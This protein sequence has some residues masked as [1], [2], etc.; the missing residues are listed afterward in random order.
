[1]KLRE[2]VKEITLQRT[3]RLIIALEPLLLLIAGFAF[4][5]PDP[6]RI[7]ALWL[8]VPSLFAR[9][10]ITR[11]AGTA[12]ILTLCMIG[13]ILLGVLNVVA[14]PYTRGLFILGRPLFGVTFVLVL[15]DRARRRG[16]LDQVLL[17]TALLALLV[18]L[19][20]ILSSQWIEKS[21]QLQFIVDRLP[22]WSG[23]PGAEG[24]FNVNEI[25][26]AMAWLIPASAAIAIHDWRVRRTGWQPTLRRWSAAVGFALM[27]AALFVGQSR[28]AIVGV[29]GAML[30]IVML[31]IPPGRWRIAALIVLALF[32]LFEVALVSKVFDAQAEITIGR[33][34]TSINGR[35]QIWD[36]AL[37]AI[38]DYPLTGVGMNM[39]R[40]AP[41]RER[42]PVPVFADRILPHAHNE[43]LQVGADLGVPGMMVF[44]A[45][46]LTIAV[47]L[48]RIVRGSH[49]DSTAYAAALAAGG[50]LA[51]HAF[52]GLG[53]AITLWDR[54]AFVSWW[55]IGLAAAAY[56]TCQIDTSTLRDV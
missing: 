7:H 2:M 40:S 5:F 26:G 13:L 22:R 23:F 44:A 21:W 25:G 46:H 8:L 31:L 10:I 4:W 28:F 16:G 41:V 37:A 47:M 9:T 34:E 45:L 19:L 33:D 14:A 52:F 18:G 32:A 53:D 51:A 48:L 17:A 38:G 27:W 15:T 42:Y 35:L 55:M 39:F 3:A 50:A 1:M 24:G 56:C 30:M 49:R 29:W 12:T 6:E 43:L 11:P 54:F 20:A 36:S